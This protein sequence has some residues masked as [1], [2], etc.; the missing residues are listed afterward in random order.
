MNFFE[1]VKSALDILNQEI[2]EREDV[3]HFALLALFSGES[4]FLLGPPGVAKSLI[5]R[6]IKFLIKDA[7]YF[8]HLMTQY[9]LPEELFGPVSLPK[10]KQG[11]Y[12]RE[13]QGY[14]PTSEVVFLDEIWK[15]SSSILNTLLVI[16]NE[17]KFKQGI[18]EINVPL[19]LL[20]SASN[21]IPEDE[22]LKALW[23]RFL[24]RMY[25]EPIKKHDTFNQYL[26]LSSNNVYE[27]NIPETIKF[28]SKEIDFVKKNLDNIIINQ[29][30]IDFINK[31]KTKIKERNEENQVLPPIEISDRRW[32]KIINIL[33]T[34]A[35]LNQRKYVS[36]LDCM[37]IPYMI[38]NTKE[39]LKELN[40]MMKNL[41]FE[42]FLQK[43]PPLKKVHETNQKMNALL[44]KITNVQIH[45]FIQENEYKVYKFFIIDEY[46]KIREYSYYKLILSNNQSN[47]LL[48]NVDFYI[49]F[50]DIEFK[51]NNLINQIINI[52]Q[53]FPFIQDDKLNKIYIEIPY[54][55][56]ILEYQQNK[57]KIFILQ[58]NVDFNFSIDSVKKYYAK[59]GSLETKLK[60]IIF[61]EQE[62]LKELN[63]SNVINSFLQR[64]NEI[65]KDHYKTFILKSQ[66]QS[67]KE[68]LFEIEKN[69]K[70]IQYKADLIKKLANV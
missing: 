65:L 31:F 67:L 4:M 55:A 59:T 25:V 13:I 37:I 52:Y 46:R 9:T 23:D 22:T 2:Y 39:D 32:K 70:Q 40:E 35:L 47:D 61:R 8:E 11:F 63:N 28:S 58:Y 44:E 26:A 27:D 30:V 6:K 24:I 33:K 17:K 66:K 36:V 53:L 43:N 34:Y 45:S 7:R 3:F 48:E 29:D 54:K 38:W 68:I 21:E 16:I 5:A 18:K 15:S 14:L 69:F 62:Y 51:K 12:E 60:D 19:K 50:N 41:I 64:F 1:K 49:N 42:E 20:I 56:K 57:I 10:L